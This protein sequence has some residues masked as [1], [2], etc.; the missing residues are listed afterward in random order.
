MFQKYPESFACQLFIPL[1]LFTRKICYLKKNW[2]DFLAVSIVFSVYKQNFTSEYLKT[3]RA[4]NVK[5]SVFV[6]CVE[7]IMY[8]S[9]YNLHDC[10]LNY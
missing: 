4:M 9:L 5:V 6:I 1:Q 8:F 2:P 7:T 3:K 10:T